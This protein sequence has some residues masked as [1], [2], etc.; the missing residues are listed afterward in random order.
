MI[1]YT[2]DIVQRGRELEE[3]RMTETV[4]IGEFRDGVDGDGR[5]T[6]VL[7]TA[8]YEG[9]AHVKYPSYAVARQNAP[10]QPIAQQDVV[11]KLPYGS[12]PVFDGDEVLVTASAADGQLVGRRFVVKGVPVTGQTTAYRITVTDPN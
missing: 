10:A 8:R 3:T 5:A 4:Q 6:R 7:R 12:G 2:G 11:V 9:K 1:G